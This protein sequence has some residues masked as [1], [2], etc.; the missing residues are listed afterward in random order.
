MLLAR[1]H[2][3]DFEFGDFGE[4]ISISLLTKNSLSLK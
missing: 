3:G 4:F 1:L 2:F